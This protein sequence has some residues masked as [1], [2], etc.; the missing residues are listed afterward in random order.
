VTTMMESLEGRQ[1][2]SVSLTPAAPSPIAIPYPT[3]SATAADSGKVHTSDIVII[4]TTDT[5]ST[6]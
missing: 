4:K 6:K 3:T 1:L 5:A 2:F